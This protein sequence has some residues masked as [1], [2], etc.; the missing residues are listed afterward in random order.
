MSESSTTESALGVSIQFHAAGR[1]AEVTINQG[2]GNIIDGACID[3]LQSAFERLSGTKGLCAIVLSAA[4]KDFSFGA[5]VEEHQRGQVETMLPS[6]HK[7]ARRVL[8]LDVFLVTAVQ[9]RCL[10][11][12]LEVALLA[13]RIIAAPGASLAQPEVALG[14]FAPL[15]SSLLH[16]KIGAGRAADLLVT[17]RAVDGA[18]AL[19][20]GL[21][22]D[23]ADLP[24]EAALTWC[25]EHL[26]QKSA[27]GLSFAVGGAR[28][29]WRAQALATLDELERSYLGPLQDSQDAHEG[30]AAFLERRRPTWS[31][32]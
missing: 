16:H 4:G 17:G 18:Q 14:V 24:A 23:L 29:P 8:E 27:L 28:A 25:E 26:A 5:S 32:Q 15:A 30:I 12:G 13:D 19:E 10:G 1:I 3:Q 20:L 6:L 21:V 9:G 11:G 31:D 22:H 2:K 7:L